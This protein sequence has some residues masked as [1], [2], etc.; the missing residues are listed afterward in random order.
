MPELTQTKRAGA[1]ARLTN[2]AFRVRV[3]PRLVIVSHAAEMIAVSSCALRLDQPNRRA[4]FYIPRG[5]VRME[6]LTPSETREYCPFRGEAVF[7][8]ANVRGRSV[9]DAA[10]TYPS[11]FEDAARL[12]DHFAFSDDLL[13]EVSV[14]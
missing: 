6:L 14:M 2:K 3:E 4:V 1:G 11:P 9:A 7:W 12:A 5:D 8:S 13:D 10:W